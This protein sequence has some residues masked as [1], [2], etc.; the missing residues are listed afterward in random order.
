VSGGRCVLV[1]EDNPGDVALIR[2]TL[3]EAGPLRFRIE[4]SGC[5]AEALG[6]LDKGGVDLVILDLGLPDCAGLEGLRAVRER[7]PGLP[8]VVLT[9]NHDPEVAA[10]AIRLGAQDYLVKGEAQGAAL[11]RSLRY[12]LE[13]RRADEAIRESEA[14]YRSLFEG[15]IDALIVFDERGRILEVNLAALERYGY[16]RE[17]LSAMTLHDLAAPDLRPLVGSRIRGTLSAGACRFDWRHRRKDGSELPI[18]VHAGPIVHAGRPCMLASIR[19]ITERRSAEQRER[20]AREVLELLNRASPAA[21]AIRDILRLIKASADIESVEIRME[22][23]AGSPV[24]RDADPVAGG[25]GDAAG[26]DGGGGRSRSTARVSLRSGDVTI[27]HLLLEDARPDR[28][29]PET[30]RFFE[31]LGASI[32]IALQRRRAEDERRS[33]EE[34]YRALYTESRDAVMLSTYESGFIAGNPATVKLFRCRDEEDFKGRTPASLSPERQPDG[35][36]SAERVGAVMRA[37]FEKGSHAFE[38][39]HRRA[40]GTEFPATVLLSRLESSPGMLLSTVRD[41]SEQS[42][43]EGQLRQAQKMEAVG[44]LAG[45]VAHDFNNHLTAISGYSE[46]ALA[47][48][49]PEDPLAQDLEEIRN[50]A[51]RATSLTRQLL[52]F[53]RKQVVELKVVDLDEIVASI[54]P[55]LRRLIGEDVSLSTSL[56]RAAALVKADVGQVEQVI[57]NLCVNARDAMPQGGRIRIETRC[58]ALDEAY[59]RAH[60]DVAP[61]PYVAL[62]VEDSGCGIDAA[63][64]AHLFEPFFTTKEV[65]KGTGLGLSTVYGIVKSCGGCIDVESE[66]GRGAT[67]TIYLPRTP[68]ALA[69]DGGRGGKPAAPSRGHE[70]ILLAEDDEIIRGLSVRVLESS[71][72]KVLCARDGADALAVSGRHEGKVDLLI[73]DVVMPGMNGRELAV[74]HAALRPD[75]RLLYVSGYTADALSVRGGLEPGVSLLEKPFTPVALLRRVREI[76]DGQAGGREA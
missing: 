18:E 74:Q 43:L 45:G 60:I 68:E 50:A 35:T 31:G 62:S 21:D 63:T 16:T 69:R 17:E 24:S 73:T 41:V 26:A 59:A 3:P 34:R 71:G 1:V 75:T 67:F 46:L 33:S 4:S 7:A 10:S 23:G 37:A 52:M 40:D 32:G 11:A 49:R 6:R 70:T 12:A 51:I 19:D 29:T 56:A 47:E 20:L 65:G 38:W 2:E 54:E 25:V 64:R 58:V 55:M 72:Y 66:V 14:R 39:T 61:G 8:I 57:M 13:R 22:Q 15:A 76:L 36:L 9:G 42:A 5:L 30:M 44:R 28:L 53:S 48:L 27:G